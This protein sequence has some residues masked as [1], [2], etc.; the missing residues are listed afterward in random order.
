MDTIER[1]AGVSDYLVAL[2][3]CL[4]FRRFSDAVATT[5]EGHH[6]PR[7]GPE[8]RRQRLGREPP[9]GEEGD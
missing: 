6:S 5:R 3:T 8:G 2:E 9:L 1:I 4:Q 7:L